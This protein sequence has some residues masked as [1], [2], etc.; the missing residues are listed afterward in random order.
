MHGRMSDARQSPIPQ[1][2]VAENIDYRQK[3]QDGK[4]E[5]RQQEAWQR[6]QAEKEL[7]DT[8]PEEQPGIPDGP[9]SPADGGD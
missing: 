7:P 4:E 5:Q 9:T 1:D 2:R 6:Q 8:N 3:A